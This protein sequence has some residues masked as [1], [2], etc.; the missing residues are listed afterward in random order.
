MKESYDYSPLFWVWTFG[1]GLSGIGL[2]ALSIPF[3]CLLLSLL[4]H[5]FL[6]SCF[7]CVRL[8]LLPLA[9]SDVRENKAQKVCCPF[10]LNLQREYTTRLVVFDSSNMTS[11]SSKSRS[12][13]KTQ[14]SDQVSL[15]QH[16]APGQ[17]VP[18]PFHCRLRLHHRHQLTDEV[19]T[20]QAL[21]HVERL[22]GG[23]RNDEPQSI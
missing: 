15:P 16:L 7:A 18:N 17:Q 8:L 5:F 13:A 3:F 23:E 1:G 9:M 20:S 12:Y 22:L 11:Q 4:L 2:F 10:S 19:G 6:L 14:P 21:D